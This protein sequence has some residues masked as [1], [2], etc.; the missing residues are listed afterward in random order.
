MFIVDTH[1]DTLLVRAGLG[2]A[3]VPCVTPQTLRAGGVTVQVCALFAGSCG[4]D[5][6]GAQAPA[7]M[8]EA[9]LG[10]LP[11]LTE[12]GVRLVESPSQAREGETCCMLSLE[13]A[14]VFGDSLDRLRQLRALGA[15]LCA[16]TWNF[17]NLLAS[18]HCAHGQRALKP[19]GWECV[20]EMA[21]LGMAVDVSHLGE[22][23]FWDLI[24][25]APLPPMASHS[26]CRALCRH[27]RNLTDDQIRAL[28][29]C[30]G[31]IG[32]NFY[33]RFVKEEGPCTLED[34][35]DHFVHIAELGGAGNMGL[36]SDFD[37]IDS[38]PQGL[39]SPADVP[40]LL[41]A[42]RGRGFTQPEIEGIAGG[43]F[44]KYFQP[45]EGRAVS[46]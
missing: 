38:A 11:Q 3:T 23:G 22:G 1:C 19:F 36:G 43:N 31:Y 18:P 27:T 6:Q 17:E 37:G 4:P 41:E 5:A 15:R 29:E 35:C 32:V 44:F 7:T 13:G 12:N 16:L 25:H 9:E 14:E 8:A 21:R 28:I 39:Q 2:D 42:L 40:A 33:T 24:F 10:A 30:G 34:V 20:R 45:F 26:C 46:A